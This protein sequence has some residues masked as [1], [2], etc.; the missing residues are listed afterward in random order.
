[1]QPKRHI[2]RKRIIGGTHRAG[3]LICEAEGKMKIW[4]PMLKIVQNSNRRPLIQ[5]CHPSQHQ[6][7]QRGE[8]SLEDHTQTKGKG[9]AGEDKGLEVARAKVIGC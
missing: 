2:N 9:V 7:T 3:D 1:M 5:G 8:Q 4:N 6:A